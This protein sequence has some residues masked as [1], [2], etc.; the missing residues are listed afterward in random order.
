MIVDCETKTVNEFSRCY[1]HGH[2]SEAKGDT[3]KIPKKEKL[4]KLTNNLE[5][6][7]SKCLG[8]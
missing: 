3:G 2:N 8:M 1:F 7:N 5:K 4:E 6:P